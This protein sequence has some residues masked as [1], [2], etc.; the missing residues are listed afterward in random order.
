MKSGLKS[1]LR[2]EEISY[3]YPGGE[4]VLEDISISVA[5]GEIVCIIGS[6][7]C[8]KT[9]LLN[10]AGGFIS[11]GSGRVLFRG[12]PAPAPDPGRIMV[13]Q[14]SDQLFPWLT[15]EKNVMFPAPGLGADAAGRLLR[16]A[17]L[18]GASGLYP[19]RLSGGMK[20][21]AV[22][23]R[24]MAPEPDVL[25][26]DEPFTALDAP[27]RRGLQDMLRG[28]RRE[29]GIA[30]VFV[31]HDIREAVYLSDRILVLSK[32]DVAEVENDLPEDRDEFSDDFVG[33][34][35]RVYDLI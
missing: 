27:T 25:L 4:P 1:L 20:Q 26:L 34:E 9:T 18:P 6:S 23:A 32:S 30:M 17:G 7:G 12:G 14:D 5:E 2:L 19:R 29:L 31:T 33:L 16:L 21:R 13:F 22:I 28:L 3:A 15:V 11:P 10:I 24:A 8:G 35:R